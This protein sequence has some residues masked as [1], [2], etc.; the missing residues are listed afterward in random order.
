[1]KQGLKFQYLCIVLSD[2]GKC[3]TEIGRHR[4]IVKAIF[5]KLNRKQSRSKKERSVV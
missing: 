1:M 3:D 4:E 2:D 5:Q